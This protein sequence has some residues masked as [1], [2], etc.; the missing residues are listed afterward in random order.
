MAT[1]ASGLT[2]LGAAVT[3]RQ[4]LDTV[5]ELDRNQR[6]QLTDVALRMIEQVYV[7]LPMKRAMHAVEPIQRLKLLKQRL[8]TKEHIWISRRD[9]CYLSFAE[10]PA[11][12]LYPSDLVSR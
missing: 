5:D 3:L 2:G 8:D 10:G 12:Q 4:F 11:Y 9:D 1:L 6:E 7:H